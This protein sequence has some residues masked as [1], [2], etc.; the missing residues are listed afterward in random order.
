MLFDN[1]TEKMYI[2]IATAI[3]TDIDGNQ[4]PQLGDFDIGAHEYTPPAP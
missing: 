1:N 4:R 3:E 2:T